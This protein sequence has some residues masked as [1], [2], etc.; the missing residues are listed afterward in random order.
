MTKMSGSSIFRSGFP[1]KGGKRWCVVAERERNRDLVFFL[2][3]FPGKLERGGKEP[4][5][6]EIG[7][8]HGR[9]ARFSLKG[10]KAEKK[11]TL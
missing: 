2:L 1:R 10:P 8:R 4:R 7:A 6:V 3:D 5:V 9:A 11:E